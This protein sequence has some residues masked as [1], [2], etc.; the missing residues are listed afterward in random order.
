[1]EIKVNKDIINFEPIKVHVDFTIISYDE[2]KE[3][4]NYADQ[5]GDVCQYNGNNSDIL[6]TLMENICDSV[7][8]GL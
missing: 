5:S 1:M 7:A 8:E 4:I 3:F 2:F 6:S